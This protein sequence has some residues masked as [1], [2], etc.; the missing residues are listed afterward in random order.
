MPST[1]TLLLSVV[2]ASVL[3]LTGCG[4]GAPRTAPLGVTL[5]TNTSPAQAASAME[6]QANALFAQAGGINSDDPEDDK[7][8]WQLVAEA[9]T[10]VAEAARMRAEAATAAGNTDAA[11]AWTLAADAA[12][13][14]AQAASALA[15]GSNIGPGPDTARGHLPPLITVERDRRIATSFG[16]TKLDHYPLDAR[17]VAPEEPVRPEEPQYY[18]EGDYSHW[19]EVA[20]QY[21]AIAEDLAD[22]AKALAADGQIDE[23]HAA[24]EGAA[25]AKAEALAAEIRAQAAQDFET[26]LAHYEAA[27]AFYEVQLKAYEAGECCW[28]MVKELSEIASRAEVFSMLRENVWRNEEFDFD[29]NAG[30]WIPDGAIMGHLAPPVVR[31]LDTHGSELRNTTLR[32]IDNINAWLPWEKHITVGDDYNAAEIKAHMESVSNAYGDQNELF[33]ERRLSEVVA[34]QRALDGVLGKNDILVN[35]LQ[36][37]GDPACPDA[38]G[39][40]TNFGI[41]VNFNYVGVIQ[42]ELLHSMGL[43]GGRTCYEAFGGS[44]D[45]N[46]FSGRQFFYSH[47]PVALFPESTMAYASPYNDEHGL[48]QIDGETLQT[49]YTREE[50]WGERFFLYTYFSF[51]GQSPLR[52]RGLL[53]PN[54]FHIWPDDLSIGSMGPWDN[55]VIRYQGSFDQN[56]PPWEGECTGYCI[57][58]E[59]AFGVDWRNGMARPWADGDRPW[60]SLAESGLTGSAKWTGDL[61]GFT[62]RQE[63]VHGDSAIDVNLANMTGDAAFTAME[64][65]AAGAAP[66]RRGSGTQWYPGDL[67]YTLALDGNYLRSN[68]GDEGYVSGRF[69]GWEHQGVVGILERPDLTGAFGAWLDEDENEKSTRPSAHEIT[70]VRGNELAIGDLSTNW[71]VENGEFVRSQPRPE[72]VKWETATDYPVV[73]SGATWDDIDEGQNRQYVLPGLYSPED[74]HHSAQFYYGRWSDNDGFLYL[75][76]NQFEPGTTKR[77]ARFGVA[78]ENDEITPPWAYGVKPLTDFA[79]N[80]GIQSL[81]TAYYDGILVGLTTS[82]KQPMGAD[83]EITFNIGPDITGTFELDHLSTIEKDGS[84]KEFLGGTL[85]HDIAVKGNSFTTTGGDSGTVTGIFAG[86]RHEAAAGTFQHSAFT[87]VFSAED[88]DAYVEAQPPASAPAPAQN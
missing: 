17:R 44:C 58:V 31:F 10:L 62:P 35:F 26:L 60:Q 66:G 4:G 11:E 13:G 27:R 37:L 50:L 38:G 25:Q 71:E 48:S 28:Q 3:A 76:G 46:S 83:V 78:L 77:I 80:P 6:T 81:G 64:H 63:A 69:V 8:T 65:W 56:L 23:A 54:R 12:A 5:S 75:G 84:L 7:N 59:P 36:G 53:E 45:P 61:V 88:S 18:S 20:D 29:E 73:D 9:W 2:L 30:E 86:E 68:G 55:N 32:A 43:N 52:E 79:D 57:Y 49:V 19:I 22:L 39:C 85:Q 67:H 74:G 70:T 21:S 87:G 47:V 72:G 82:T 33:D 15:A 40:A 41:E 14:Y 51:P 1:N 24:T 34:A 16:T 42:H